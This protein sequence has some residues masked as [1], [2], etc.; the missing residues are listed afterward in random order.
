MQKKN[1][2]HTKRKGRIE[3]IILNP[4]PKDEVSPEMSAMLDRWHLENKD[5]DEV[6]QTLGE[7]FETGM[8]VRR[9][10]SKACLHSLK[11]AKK[12]I[13][14]ISIPRYRKTVLRIVSAA[15]VVA[16]IGVTLLLQ[17]KTDL[18]T[19]QIPYTAE[20]THVTVEAIEGIQKDIEL[21]DNSKI[22]VNSSTRITYPE[23]FGEERHVQLQGHARFEVER[24]TNRPFHVH[25]R[26]LDVRVLGTDFHVR[27][28][29]EEAYTEV[30]LY[31]GSVEVS[32][33]S[34][35]HALKPGEKLHYNHRNGKIN[36]EKIEVERI[37]DW[38]SDKIFANRKT[39]SELFAMITNYYDAKI[40]FDPTTFNDSELYVLA[41][42]KNDPIEKVMSAVASVSG[43]NFSYEIDER[44]KT[45]Y[46]RRDYESKRGK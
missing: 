9:T 30:V 26:H 32:T 3:E 14:A 39:L 31:S 1:N 34:R 22:W 25:T 36:I 45:I 24:D 13:G 43:Q 18:K 20:A 37:E 38:R 8:R 44:E 16:G 7:L 27:E 23:T 29:T 6:N 33:Q 42:R 10:P 15:A 28:C 46:V 19:I 40:V 4:M 2:I 11:K 21:S 12:R 5:D 17:Q 35:T 41:F